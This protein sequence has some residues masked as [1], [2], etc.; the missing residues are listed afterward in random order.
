MKIVGVASGLLILMTGSCVTTATNAASRTPREVTEGFMEV[1][2]AS[3]RDLF[4]DDQFKRQYFSR[5]LRRAIDQALD[6]ADEWEPPPHHPWGHPAHQDRFNRTIFNA[7]DLPT[8]FS[9]GEVSVRGTQATVKVIYR[10]GEGSQYEG[11]ERV[12]SVKLIREPDGWR[13]DD[14]VTHEGQFIPAGTLRSQLVEP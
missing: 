4:T 5:G 3:E 11:D 7:W 1:L 13:I 2:F 10:W 14:V 8:S 9:I 6:E 12:T